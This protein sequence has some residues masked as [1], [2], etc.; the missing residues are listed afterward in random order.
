[1]QC[2]YRSEILPV[3]QSKTA[4]RFA[5][6]STTRCSKDRWPLVIAETSITRRDIY[7]HYSA[8]WQCNRAMLVS[9]QD[10]HCVTNDDHREIHG[11]HTM[12]LGQVVTIDHH[13]HWAEPSAPR[14]RYHAIGPSHLLTITCLSP[15]ISINVN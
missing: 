8:D 13:K 11:H 10:I 7:N 2:L 4:K 9:C 6:V 12:P 14:P 5:S 1:M 3:R 15:A